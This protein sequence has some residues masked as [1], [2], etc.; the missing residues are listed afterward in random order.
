[1]SRLRVS[2]FTISLDGYGAGPAQSEQN[3]L[4]VRGE[5]LH[6]WMFPPPTFKAEGRTNLVAG[7]R[8]SHFTIERRA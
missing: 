6:P 3:P 4:G 2:G 7:E 1:M 8:A 5:E